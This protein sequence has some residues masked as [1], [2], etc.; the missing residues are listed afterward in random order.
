MTDDERAIRALRDRWMS[1]TQNG[2]VEA[3]LDLMTDDVVFLVPGDEPIGKDAFA[4]ASRQM[5][6][7]RVDGESEVV[8]LNV[9]GDWAWATAH[10]KVAVTTPGAPGAVQRS[11][12]TL[13]V[14]RKE[15]DG[16]WRLARN[17]NLVTEDRAKKRA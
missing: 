8:E 7:L 17:A 10:I 14:L 2:D 13:S 6:D 16:K 3:V 5:S 11:G 9:Q 4:A 1:A 15:P 12:Y